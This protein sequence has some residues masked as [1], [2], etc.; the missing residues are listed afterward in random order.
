MMKQILSEN[1]I[2]FNDLE[3]EIYEIACKNAR[4]TM[5]EILESMDTSL[6]LNRDKKVY[7]HK[8]KRKTTIKTIMGEV[9][10]KRTIYETTNVL[11][12]KV[13]LYLLDQAIGLET[14]GKVST[15]LALKIVEHASISSFRNSANNISS[16]TG[17]SISH[18]GVW[19]VI[20][21]IG[22]KLKE[23]EDNDANLAANGQITGTNETKIIFEEADGV[24]IN[25]QGKDRPRKGRRSELKVAVAYDGWEL[26]GKNRYKLRNKVA[27]AGFDNS[28]NFQKRKE[29][30]IASVFNT[31][32][33]EIR[34][35]NGDG[36]GWIK[37]GLI[38]ET[39]HFQLDP[40]HLNRDIISKVRNKNESNKIMSLLKDKKVDAALE[41]IK[42]LLEK[43]PDLK[44]SA[45]LSELYTYLSNNKEGLIP[46]QQRGLNIPT[47]P[48]GVV[49]RNLGT[50]EHQI[51]DIIAQRMK[52]RKASWSK[53]G[54]EKL[55]KILTLK[56]TKKLTQKITGISTIIL[57]ETY[58]EEVQEILSAA[59]APKKDGHG[60][61]Y[62][63]RGGMPF[64]GACT[65]NG[66][67]AIQGM[68]SYQ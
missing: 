3:K 5:V 49:Y 23:I 9:E 22:S 16:T 38:D 60:Y 21:S 59:K 31:D 37:G 33:V 8:G 41:H 14:F 13:H 46:Y 53:N 27:V 24:W 64:V 34:I 56:I 44:E 63:R 28:R 52:N 57:P 4:E 50:M 25:M 68:L 58:V 1:E 12:E 65:T 11:G 32:E 15:N 42:E 20:Q 67:R 51:C 35:L 18:S 43:T 61:Q 62:P 19:N 39:V 36:G 48:A 29:G 40:F 45:K 26:E 54:A 2:N 17:Q 55:S 47:P 10:F 7:R 6:Q 30:A 66:R